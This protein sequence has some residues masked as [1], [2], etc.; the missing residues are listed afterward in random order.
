MM[1][2]MMLKVVDVGILLFRHGGKPPIN[3]VVS[4]GSIF[5]LKTLSD[6]HGTVPLTF[7]CHD[8]VTFAMLIK[9]TG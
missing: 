1:H 6:S 5:L 9:C 8:V 3:G 2:V 4:K 7:L